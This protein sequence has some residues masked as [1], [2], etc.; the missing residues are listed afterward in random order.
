MASQTD[1]GVDVQVIVDYLESQA[2]W[3]DQKAAEYP[4]DTRNNRSAEGLRMLAAHVRQL[5]PGDER[6]RDLF[7]RCCTDLG[8]HPLDVFLAGD[9]VGYAV[10]RFRFHDPNDDCDAFL[11]SLAAFALDD[12][13]ALMNNIGEPPPWLEGVSSQRAGHATASALVDARR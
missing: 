6:V 13:V 12:Q 7:A 1:A 8:G 11:T 5:P 9:L 4:D 3:R 2:A 10:A